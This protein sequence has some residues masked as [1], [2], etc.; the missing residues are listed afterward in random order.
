MPL[1]DQC[2]IIRFD[3]HPVPEDSPLRRIGIESVVFRAIGFKAEEGLKNQRFKEFAERRNY[4]ASLRSEEEI[5]AAR[6]AEEEAERK[7][8]ERQDNETEEKKPDPVEV[9]FATYSM[10]G[11]LRRSLFLINGE[12]VQQFMGVDSLESAFDSLLE[13]LPIASAKWLAE[14][15]MRDNGLIET[16]EQE[17]NV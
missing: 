1:D 12:G 13:T 8:A 7:E 6:K 5:K 4:L 2:R 10:D 14:L 15:A 11:V 16:E 9:A 17:G 3:P